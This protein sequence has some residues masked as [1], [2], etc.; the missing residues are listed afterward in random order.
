VNVPQSDIRAF[1]RGELRTLEREVRR[2]LGRTRDNATR[3]H[4]E[5]ALVRIDRILNPKD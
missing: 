5:D 2:A 3:L 1:V 4:L